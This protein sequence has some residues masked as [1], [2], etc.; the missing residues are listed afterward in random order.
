MGVVYKAEDTTLGRFVALKFLPDDLAHDRSALDRFRREAKAASALNHS[1]ICTI[2]EVGE[3]NACAFIAMEYLDGITLKHRIGNNP[4]ALGEVL[5]L[6]TEIADA[7]DAAHAE[8]IIHRD[9]KPANIFVTKRSHAKVLDFGLAKLVPV[10]EGAGVSAMPTATADEMLTSPG[11]TLGTIAYMSP[12]QARGEELDARTDLFSFGAVLYEMATGRLAFPGNTAAL[13]H[14][15]ILHRAPVSVSV[16]NAEVPPKL[17]EIIS[18]A[19]EKD[20]NLRYQNASEMR[21]DLQRLNR[22]MELTELRLADTTAASRLIAPRAQN[23]LTGF[24][25]AIA[26]LVIAGAIVFWRLSVPSHHEARMLMQRRITTNPP[27][28]PVYAAAVSPD[29]RYL[30][31]ADFTG[32]YVR[33]FETGETHSLPLPQSFCFR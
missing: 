6:G 24:M 14:D 2:Y 18:K 7:L 8:G 33:L 23:K 13:T 26:I 11:S 20:R 16:L 21:A 22:D 31:Y 27:E 17:T 1:N 30:A 19:L 10:A 32:V 15:A 4:L 9:I 28:N 3:E 29:G 5:H 12:E 25:T